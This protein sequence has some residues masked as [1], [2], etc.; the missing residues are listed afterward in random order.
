M[1]LRTIGQE[2][3]A[4][5]VDCARLHESSKTNRSA[6]YAAILR[7]LANCKYGITNCI[8]WLHVAVWMRHGYQDTLLF[9]VEQVY[10]RRPPSQYPKVCEFT[11]NGVSLAGA[12]ASPAN[13]DLLE[14]KD[15]QHLSAWQR[16]DIL[17]WFKTVVAF[18]AT[19][20]VQIPHTRSLHEGRLDLGT[21]WSYTNALHSEDILL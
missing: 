15:S 9:T 8:L 4:P 3:H 5:L 11:S 14:N 2:W 1:F 16:M 18:A 21:F 17:P 10:C 19:K 7:S 6:A 20:D 12:G 13:C